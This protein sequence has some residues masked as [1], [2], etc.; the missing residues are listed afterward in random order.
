MTTVAVG[1]TALRAL[2]VARSSATYALAFALGCVLATP[3]IA[4]RVEAALHEP[5]PWPR[6]ALG[7]AAVPPGLALIF[8][9]SAA[10]LAAGTYN[11]FIYFR[12]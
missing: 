6:I 11:P 10:K 12:F 2:A 4:R 3:F 8:I 5:G 7:A 9:V 1:S